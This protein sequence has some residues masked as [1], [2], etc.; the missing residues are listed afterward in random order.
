MKPPIY[1]LNDTCFGILDIYSYIF[2]AGSGKY[3]SIAFWPRNREVGDFTL[4]GGFKI[5]GYNAGTDEFTSI[6]RASAF[7]SDSEAWF[8]F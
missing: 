6:P 7:L 3:E 8:C 5:L 2:V 1:A 4:Q